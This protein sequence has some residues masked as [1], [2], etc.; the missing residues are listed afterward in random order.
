MIATLVAF[1]VVA[2]ALGP[3][4]R[5][6][7]ATTGRPTVV[8]LDVTLGESPHSPVTMQVGEILAVYLRSATS[9]GGFWDQAQVGPGEILTAGVDYPQPLPSSPGFRERYEAFTAVSPGETL[10]RLSYV[11]ANPATVPRSAPRD[12]YGLPRIDLT[13]K[14]DGPQLQR[15]SGLHLSCTAAT[16]SAAGFRV[17]ASRVRAHHSTAAPCLT[18][19][20]GPLS[21]SLDCTTY[22]ETQ[23][24]L[25]F[26]NASVYDFSTGPSDFAAVP[27]EPGASINLGACSYVEG[28]PYGPRGGVFVVPPGASVSHYDF[29]AREPSGGLSGRLRWH[30]PGAEVGGDLVLP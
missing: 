14:I 17:D 30:P 5:L 9:I 18:S 24:R 20:V 12:Q 10:L 8:R 15:P 13:V 4:K 26:H 25:A 11:A 6:V 21:Q 28:Q 23:I 16:C 19:S 1:G 27:S 29:C 22:F 3:G 7:A 2:T